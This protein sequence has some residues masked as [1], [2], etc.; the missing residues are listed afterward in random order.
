MKFTFGIITSEKNFKNTDF[1]FLDLII[2]SIKDQNIPEYEIIVVGG[3][4]IEGE[5]VKHIKFDETI[6]NMWIT[7]KKNLITE[8]AKYENIVYMHDY[9]CL[10][11]NW[12]KCFLEYGDDFFICMNKIVNVDDISR[13]KDWCL[14]SDD[15]NNFLK[16]NRLVI[17]YDVENLNKMMYIPGYY[18]VAKK[19]VM[20][21]NKLNE[22]LMWGQGEDVEWSLRVR[23]KY[24]FSINEKSMVKSLKMMPVMVECE[25]EDIEILNNNITGYN[26]DAT[27][28]KLLYSH[29]I[30]NHIQRNKKN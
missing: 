2:K 9:I 15:V 26:N 4:H 17:P 19:S 3:K 21:E 12:Y 25:K 18:W 27:Y 29:G 13:V 1:D 30:Y 22:D 23:N 24:K 28:T 8:N 5:N 7:R 14:W 16:S 10:L 6:K 11:D 20:L